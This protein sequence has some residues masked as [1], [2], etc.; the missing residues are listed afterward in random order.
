MA[1]AADYILVLV[2]ASDQREAEK[3]ARGLLEEKL[4]ACVNIMSGVSSFFWWQ[5]AL[6]RAEESVLLIKSRRE[7]FEK[8]AA[9]VKE[10]H[11]YEL[12]EIIA[13]PLT[14][15][16]TEYLRWIDESVRKSE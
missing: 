8:I 5:G 13:L 16:H 7:C 2:T 4:A 6:D 3:I 9:R 14:A 15:G 1:L 10:L 11:S 12:P